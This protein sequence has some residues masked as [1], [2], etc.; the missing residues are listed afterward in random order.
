MP[1]VHRRFGG[2]DCLRVRGRKEGTSTCFLFGLLFDT[3]DEGTVARVRAD[4]E[5]KQS[6]KQGRDR[7]RGERY[8]ERYYRNVPSPLF[9]EMKMNRRASCQ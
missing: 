8:F 7:D 4:S 3:V 1:S 5:A 2:T 6:V 9:R